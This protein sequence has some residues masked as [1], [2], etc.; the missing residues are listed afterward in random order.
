MHPVAVSTPFNIDLEFEIAAFHKRLFAWFAD[1]VILLFYAKGMKIF[2]ADN[3]ASR[4]HAYPVGLDIFL[5]T[6][7]MLLYHLLME[8]VFQGQSLGKKLAGIRVIS[9]EGG[10]PGIGQYIIRWAFRIWEWPLV[11]GFVQMHSLG[12]YFQVL[13]TG[14]SGLLVVIVIAVTNKSQ[15][16]G[17]IAAGTTVVETRYNYSLG[18][19]LFLEVKKEDYTVQFP[20]VMKLSD[21]DINAI[22]TVLKQANLTRRYDTAHRIAFKI[23]DVLK[24]ESGMDVLHFLEQLLS[25]YNY[26]AT[27]E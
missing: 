5:V 10:E 24:I 14:L 3:F 18:D 22:K 15:R 23:K 20:E 13:A 12:I 9:L 6:L 27:K 19:T 7:P 11:F 1:L 26:L 25:D 4:G 16:L 21:R 17:D 8:S 2:L